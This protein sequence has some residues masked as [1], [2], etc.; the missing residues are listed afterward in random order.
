MAKAAAVGVGVN[1]DGRGGLCLAD[2]LASTPGLRPMSG[3]MRGSN[4]R[5]YSP[6]VSSSDKLQPVLV[7]C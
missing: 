3:D 2:L 6:C 5:W 7:L 1:Q 4:C